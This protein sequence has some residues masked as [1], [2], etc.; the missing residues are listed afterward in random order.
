M[1]AGCKRL[2]GLDDHAYEQVANYHLARLMLSRGERDEARTALRELVDS[3][4]AETVEGSSEPR[5]P[6]LLAQAEVR[7]RELDPSSATSAG[8]QLL[9]PGGGEAGGPGGG[10]DIDPAQL[11]ELIRQFQA[12]QQGGGGGEGGGE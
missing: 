5:F 2:A 12:Q 4:R 7:L 1:S 9:G 8:P 10:G 6:Y 3:L 11:Q